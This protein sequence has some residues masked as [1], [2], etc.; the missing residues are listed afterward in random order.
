MDKSLK[1]YHEPDHV[2]VMLPVTDSV[3]QIITWV[4]S[5][6]VY[7]TEQGVS[8]LIIDTREYSE[9]FSVT[10]YMEIGKYAALKKPVSLKKVANITAERNVSHDRFFE[11]VVRNRG[12]NYKYFTD[13]DQALI[14]LREH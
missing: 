12:I 6:F 13:Y 10:G 2:Y 5:I 7:S 14:W 8:H 9:R 3:A 11:N 1:F 4:E